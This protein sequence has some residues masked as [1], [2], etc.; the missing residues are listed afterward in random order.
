MNMRCP[1]KGNARSCRKQQDG[2][3]RSV[4]QHEDNA[5]APDPASSATP[6]GRGLLV[7]G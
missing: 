7:T 1:L 5:S 6:K 4:T 2:D 3:Y